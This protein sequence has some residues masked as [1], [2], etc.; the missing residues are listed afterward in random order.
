[1]VIRIS[2]NLVMRCNTNMGHY[3]DKPDDMKPREEDSGWVNTVCDN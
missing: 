1:M 3:V 2:N